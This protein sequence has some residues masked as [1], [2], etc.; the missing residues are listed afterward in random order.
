[1]NG[2]LPPCISADQRCD[3][4]T[5]CIG[6]EDELD[7]NCPCGPEGA[8][9]L[10][11]GIVPYQGRVE[12]CKS[13]RWSTICSNRFYYWDN[14]DAAVVCHQ[15][16]YPREGMHQVMATDL[17]TQY[18]SVC[19]LVHHTTGAEAHQRKFL[20]ADISQPLVFD[21]FQCRGSENNLLE[22]NRGVGRVCQHSED[23]S[24][25]CSESIVCVVKHTES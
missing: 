16:G 13:G 25:V 20:D 19:M 12:F 21:H 4:V 3:G 11:D 1:M 2:T 5:D 18:Y 6:G 8:V 22:C 9:R 7:H 14:S 17:C 10:V 24:V 15:L 23:V